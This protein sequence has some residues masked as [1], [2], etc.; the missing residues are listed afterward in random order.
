M[1]EKLRC[2]VEG[3]STDGKG[4]RTVTWVQTPSPSVIRSPLMLPG[5]CRLGLPS[6]PPRVYLRW[7]TEEG[8]CLD[9]FSP[10]LA[11]RGRR[12]DEVIGPDQCSP[13]RV[14]D[15]ISLQFAGCCWTQPYHLE[16]NSNPKMGALWIEQPLEAED[17]EE[18]LCRKEVLLLQPLDTWHHPRCPARGAVGAPCHSRG[19]AGSVGLSTLLR[20]D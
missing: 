4:M 20:G 19:S 3:R 18:G 15:P 7:F 1:A 2:G 10:R 9:S 5:H 8:V 6:L 17:E 12:S 13:G 11:F 16:K 14:E